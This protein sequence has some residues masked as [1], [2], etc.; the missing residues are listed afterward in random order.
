M[1]VANIYDVAI[2]GAGPAGSATAVHLARAGWRVALVD[3]GTFP[4]HKPCAEYLSPAAEP[5]LRDLGVM[6][7]LTATRP[8]RLKGFRI[9]VPDGSWFQGD[10]AATR[11]DRGRS[12]FETGLSITR[13]NLDNALVGGA[14]AAGAEVREGWRLARL[15]TDASTHLT[16]LHPAGDQ[17]PMQ[18]RLVVAADGLHSTIAKRLG[19]QRES[20]MRK[21]ALVAHVR[22]IADLGDY[23]EMHV[24]GRRYVGLAPLEP[25]TAGDL[26]NVAM[27]VDEDRDARNLAGH[28]QAFLLAAL[29]TFPKLAGRLEKL[30]VERPTLTTSHLCVQATRLVADG[31][32]L[33]GDA[34]GYY[35]PFTGEG[36]FRA[37]HGAHMVAE[38]A[39]AALHADDTSAR[40]LARYERRYHA[41]FRGKRLI[42]MIIQSAVQQPWLMNH[43]GAILRRRKAM[44]D[45]VVAVT[46]DFLSP[47]AVLNPG[48]LLRLVF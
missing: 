12:L 39:D 1:S 30:T 16:T 19:L 15:A 7:E 20:R 5:F 11:D 22:G 26:C 8:G 10:F 18:A 14:R 34:A 9:Y 29:A 6:D 46:G 36:I 3:R 17:R 41:A 43:I 38:V 47:W 42:E 27:V 2:V 31:V 25:S 21:I 23:G 4:R 33:A 37:L 45:T 44:A 35:D 48:F 13:F 24:A 40:F 28:P 32:M